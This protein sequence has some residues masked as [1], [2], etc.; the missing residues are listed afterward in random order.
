K[1]SIVLTPNLLRACIFLGPTPRKTPT[2]SPKFTNITPF[3]I[4]LKRSKRTHI[5]HSFK[6]IKYFTQQKLDKDTQFDL[7]H[8]SLLLS[9]HR[10][11]SLSAAL[12]LLFTQ[13]RPHP[14][15]E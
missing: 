4:Y 15:S 5:S 1:S 7:L 13:S 9:Q 8:E 12:I 11:Q 2:E 3:K 14:I 6:I 10:C